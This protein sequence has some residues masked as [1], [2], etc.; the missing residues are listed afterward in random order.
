MEYNS[1]SGKYNMDF[2]LQLVKNCKPNSPILRFYGWSPY[3]ISIGTNQSFS[4]IDNDLVQGNNINVV[5]R[6]T[7]GRAIL[8]AE[9]LTYS[10]IIPNSEQIS[11]KEIYE[12]I[13]RAIV[14]GLKS[15]SEKLNGIELE[16]QSP[17]FSDLLNNPSGA[18]C[19]ASTAKSEIKYNG[20]KLVGSA[21]RKLGSTILQHGS[22]LIG[23]YHRNL[24]N[25]LKV[26]QEEKSKLKIKIR[27][28]TTEISTILEDDVNIHH[29]QNSIVTGFEQILNSQFLAETT[30]L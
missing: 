1:Y 12:D 8:H 15:Y 27:E 28:K 6:P 20:K 25:Y 22:I 21:Q 2:D 29:L 7:G 5:K 17:N 16:N 26:D 11:G 10:V 23:Q 18:L 3:C 9:E 4:E 13:S 24:V 30:S 19:F 14:F